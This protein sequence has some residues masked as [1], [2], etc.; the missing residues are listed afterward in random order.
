M[1]QEKIGKF[2]AELR[3]NKH[4]T[5]EDLAQ[6]LGV[7]NR[8][9]SRWENGNNMPDLSLLKLL[10]EELDISINELLSGEKLAKEKYQE[11][12]EENILNTIDYSNK[13][14]KSNKKVYIIILISIFLIISL[15]IT[16]FFID[17]RRMQNKEPVFFS[18]W[19]FDYVPPIDLSEEEIYIVIEDYLVK[20]NDN[21]LKNYNNEKSF[22]SFK[23]YLI[24]EIKKDN[25]YYDYLWVLEESYYLKGK[26]IIQ[27]S[28][29]S[30]PYKFIIKNENDKYIVDSY[31]IPRD[32]SFYKVDIKKIFP[33][34]VLREMDN[35]HFDGTINKLELEIKEKVKLYF[36]L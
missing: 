4:L 23:P 8:T 18:N 16:I 28:G 3:K 14:I 19:G 21:E 36:H 5:Q 29:S 17:V 35:V 7:S 6:K 1:E 34:D 12:L 32:G 2:I 10:C 33:K 22:V 9:I 24:E 25:L 11:K 15:F 13:K 20:R 30:M 26:E 27:E 31:Q